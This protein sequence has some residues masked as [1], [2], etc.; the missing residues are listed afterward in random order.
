MV[1][2]AAHEKKELIILKENGHVLNE[3]PGELS[4]AV[5]DW[6]REELS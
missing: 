4:Q 6:I 3:S 5:Y 2:N 1:F